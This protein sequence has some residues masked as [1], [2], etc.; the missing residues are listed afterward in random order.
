[1][2]NHL[3]AGI[4]LLSLVTVLSGSMC[5]PRTSI[6]VWNLSTLP[7]GVRFLEPDGSVTDWVTI[8]PGE[9]NLGAAMYKP[10][11]CKVEVQDGGM[12]YLLPITKSDAYKGGYV[13]V[14]CGSAHS[15]PAAK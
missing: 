10:E 15:G 12:I 13:V 2:K 7:V 9:R 14:Y 8:P 11:Q 4:V 6:D 1:V 3:L 5:A